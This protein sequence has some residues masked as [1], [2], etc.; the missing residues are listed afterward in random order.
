MLFLTCFY[1]LILSPI[2]FHVHN[3]TPEST[4]SLV[5]VTVTIITLLLSSRLSVV[6]LGTG[7]LHYVDYKCA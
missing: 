5:R 1:T 2:S 4:V 6:E 7:L 3:A